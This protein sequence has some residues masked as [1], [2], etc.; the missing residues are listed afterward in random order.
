MP[1]VPAGTARHR[2][3]VVLAEEGL[4]SSAGPSCCSFQ[5]E[6]DEGAVLHTVDLKSAVELAVIEVGD[7]PCLNPERGGSG[8][9]RLRDLP[10]F[11]QRLSVAALPEQH[12]VAWEIRDNEQMRSGVWRK[13]G[14]RRQS[15]GS[16]H[17]LDVAGGK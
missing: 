9:D 4:C 14:R 17:S 3:R 16:V 12:L 13:L 8:D 1:P 6:C 10:R 11:E 7:R 15:D 2:C 5:L